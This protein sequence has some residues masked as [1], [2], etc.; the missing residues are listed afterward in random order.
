M[1]KKNN[2]K[3]YL[4]ILSV[5]LIVYIISKY[6]I[7]VVPESNF[8]MSVLQID[9]AQIASLNIKSNRG[10][11]KPLNFLKED[12]HWKVVQDD[13]NSIADEQ[14]VKELLAAL[15]GLKIQN[16]AGTDDSKWKEHQLTDSLAIEVEI[17]DN[18][19]KLLKDLYIGKFTYKQ[20]NTPYAQPGRSNG[21]GL[22]YVRLAN[23]AESFIVE[24]FLPM[25]FNRQFNSFR[26]HHLVKV[27]PSEIDKISFNYPMDTA[28]NITRADSGTFLINAKDTADAKKVTSFFRT[29]AQYKEYQF[30]EH[31]AAG[32]SPLFSMDI[33]GKLLDNIKLS[34]YD[35]DSLNYVI[36]SSQFPETYFKV[37]KDQLKKKLF[38]SKQSFIQ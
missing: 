7:N 36:A 2:N 5:L 23:Q 32:T 8:D 12:G 17:Y 16:L 22:T 9:T 3:L 38:K 18:D 15:A 29:A 25:T 21:Y 33:S 24:G 31:F 6:V 20:N 4:I 19:S 11:K 28:F 30:D 27:D 35:N 34:V 37:R 10:Q 14:S 1:A 26:N 13:K